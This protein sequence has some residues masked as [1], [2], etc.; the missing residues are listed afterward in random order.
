MPR[1]LTRQQVLVVMEMWEEGATQMDIADAIGMSIHCLEEHR[2]RG[3]LKG[4]LP[5]RCGAN[6]RSCGIPDNPTPEQRA[7]VEARKLEV[8]SRWTPQQR[9][10]RSVNTQPPAV[11]VSDI[12][13]AYRVALNELSE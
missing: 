11:R 13:A 12:L 9:L 7:E 10:Q 1:E 4:K 8:Q 5:A 3:Q 6:P 2:L